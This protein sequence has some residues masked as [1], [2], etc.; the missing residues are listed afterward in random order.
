MGIGTTIRNLRKEKNISLR[1]LA[2]LTKLS[3]STISDIEN[4]KSKNPT[5]ETLEKIATALNID[6][7]YLLNTSLNNMHEDS[8][9]E[10]FSEEFFD[11]SSAHFIQ[12]IRKTKNMS[13]ENLEKI[14]SYIDS[15]SEDDNW[16][17]F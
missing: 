10:L 4:C 13:K 6:V 15:L 3:K 5:M 1:K 8:P 9:N 17:G 14:A 11:D 7:T 16:K 2:E 12:A